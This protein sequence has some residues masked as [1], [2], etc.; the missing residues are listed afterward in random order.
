[1]LGAGR[2]S[3]G[4]AQGR[5]LGARGSSQAA[6]SPGN[7]APAFPAAALR[8]TR[9]LAE[10]GDLEPNRTRYAQHYANERVTQ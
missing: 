4:G 8:P 3:A 5:R 2:G 6:L 7:D 9:C 1:M 10:L